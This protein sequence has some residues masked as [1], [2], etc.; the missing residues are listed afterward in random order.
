MRNAV[1]RALNGPIGMLWRRTVSRRARNTGCWTPPALEAVEPDRLLRLRAEMKLPGEAWLQFEAQPAEDGGTR[2]VQTAYFAP[3]GLLG[4]VYWYSLYP[5]HGPIFSSMIAALGERAEAG[6]AIAA[7][8]P[9]VHQLDRS[10]S[11]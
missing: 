5:V 10:R 11:P 2:L 6:G 3:K 8:Q 7:S 1:S 9:A 4:L